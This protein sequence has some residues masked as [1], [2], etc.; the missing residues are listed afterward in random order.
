VKNNGEAF[1]TVGTTQQTSAESILVQLCVASYRT[2]KPHPFWMWAWPR[3][4]QSEVW[5]YSK[6]PE[7]HILL[8]QLAR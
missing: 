2:G 8:L 5:F 7:R 6:K 1:V 3:N 4:S